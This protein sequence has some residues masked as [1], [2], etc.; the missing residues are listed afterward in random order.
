[1]LSLFYVL[2]INILAQLSF[3]ILAFQNSYAIFIVQNN[4]FNA[5]DFS[6][7]SQG[8]KSTAM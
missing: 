8:E 5:K 3:N 7:Q 2:N 6:M 4:T 1:M